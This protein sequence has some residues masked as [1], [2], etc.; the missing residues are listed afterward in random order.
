MTFPRTSGVETVR[1][2]VA[3][4]VL[5]VTALAWTAGAQTNTTIVAGQS[6]AGIR[7]GGNV[8]EATS[9]LGS[10][11]DRTDSQSGKYTVYDWP[12]RPVGLFAEKESGR[13]VFII[14]ALTDAYRTDRGGIAAGSER[15]AVET[16]YG[17]EFT[18]DESQASTSLIY[19]SLGIAFVI[20]K[21]GVMNGRVLWIMV[22]VPGQWKQITEGL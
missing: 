11:F 19:D 6:A 15:Q 8:N 14:V 10:L 5:F 22:F 17:R 7:I 1:R 20:G 4:A 13:I 2:I 18:T 9:V 12:L 3:I 16:A 21:N